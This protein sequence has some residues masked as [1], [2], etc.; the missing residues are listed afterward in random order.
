MLIADVIRGFFEFFPLWML[1]LALVVAALRARGARDRAEV[2]AAELLFWPVGL[3]GLWGFVFHVFF[4][5]VASHA[6]GWQPSGFET[7]VGMANL[8]LGV[9]GVT[10]RRASRGYRLATA[11][12]TACFLWGAAANHV[13]EILVA[14]NF[15]PG[16]AG[17]ILWTD[18][19]IPAFALVAVLRSSEHRWRM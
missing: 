3:A 11:V 14:R 1:L 9:T 2:F 4:P 7:E 5:G 13:H 18:I 19:L 6:I 16:N 15:A 10:S 12:A 8:A 17:P